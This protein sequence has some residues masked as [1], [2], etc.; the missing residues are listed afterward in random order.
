MRLDNSFLTRG[1]PSFHDFWLPRKS[2]FSKTADFAKDADVSNNFADKEHV[3]T[4]FENQMVVPNSMPNI[5]FL[6]LLNRI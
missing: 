6:A 1:Q 2:R 5:K 3:L 4:I